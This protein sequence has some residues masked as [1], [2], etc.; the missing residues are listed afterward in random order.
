MHDLPPQ[1]PRRTS[2]SL[3]GAE[4]VKHGSASGPVDDPQV[5]GEHKTARAA[6]EHAP[7]Q[8]DTKW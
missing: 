4:V 6:M 7:H 1:F 8:P 2:A 3:S 5:R